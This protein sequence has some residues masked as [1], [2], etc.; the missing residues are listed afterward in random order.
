MPD[1]LTP[2]DYCQD[3][4]GH[5]CFALDLDGAVQA[6]V[7]SVRDRLIERGVL[8]QDS[9]HVW[10]LHWHGF[11]LQRERAA[12]MACCDFCSARPVCWLVPCASFTLPLVPGS[13]AQGRSQGDWA[14][15]AP[16]GA[17]VSAGDRAALL[18]RSHDAAALT[19]F[20]TV[21]G[22]ARLL[23]RVKREL[24]RRFWLHY[25]GG[26]VEIPAHPYGH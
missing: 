16:C 18:A 2:T 4:C 14:A 12:D 20:A 21:P 8:T 15:C 11:D 3:A 1:T 22:L 13:G 19:L 24:H 23:R 6:F 25:Q 9:A 26:A 5:G 17:A 7:P 10:R